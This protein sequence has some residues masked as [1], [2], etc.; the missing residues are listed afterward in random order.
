MYYYNGSSTVN[1]LFPL[2]LFIIIEA[3]S[4]TGIFAYK[5]LPQLE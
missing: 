3:F 2:Q 1:L 4:K 5:S